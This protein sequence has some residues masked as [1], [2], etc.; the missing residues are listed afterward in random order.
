MREIKSYLMIEQVDV[1]REELRRKIN[2]ELDKLNSAAEITDMIKE[3]DEIKNI[4]EDLKLKL[5][6]LY[7][8]QLEP[9]EIDDELYEELDRLSEELLKNP[10]RDCRL[11]ML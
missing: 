10:K 11:R 2:E 7:A 8:Q 6:K 5:L 3:I 1:I 9:E 4:L